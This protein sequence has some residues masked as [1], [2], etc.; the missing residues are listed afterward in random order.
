MLMAVEAVWGVIEGIDA[1]PISHDEDTDVWTFH[2]PRETTGTVIAE[3]W[4]RDVAGNVAYR[5]AAL[6]ME[7]GTVKCVRWLNEW[8]R[9][10][11]HY[12]QIEASVAL[13]RPSV[14]MRPHAC[15]MMEA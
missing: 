15:P 13:G 4:A 2:V 7:A 3:F 12:P 9:C 14:I 11:M 10:I 1:L 8:G 5:A 6:E